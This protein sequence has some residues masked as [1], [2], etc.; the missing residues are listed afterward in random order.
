M[1]KK[2]CS[3]R[4][5]FRTAKLFVSPKTMC[6]VSGFGNK[7]FQSPFLPQNPSLSLSLSIVVY[8]DIKTQHASLGFKLLWTS[9]FHFFL[10]LSSVPISPNL[11]WPL[12]FSC[13]SFWIPWLDLFTFYQQHFTLQFLTT[14]FF[15]S[16]GIWLHSLISH[17]L[18]LVH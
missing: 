2:V 12:T 7:S 5:E 3:L 8:I 16:S 6:L 18:I 11:L 4:G 10:F 15:P 13:H 17:F 1:L 14:L 9:L